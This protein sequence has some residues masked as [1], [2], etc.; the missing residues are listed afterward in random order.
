ML[1]FDDNM[2]TFLPHA[3]GMSRWKWQFQAHW[4]RR[5]L[6]TLHSYNHSPVASHSY[7][8]LI[9]SRHWQIWLA[10]ISLDCCR[11]NIC[12]ENSPTLNDAILDDG[13]IEMKTISAGVGERDAQVGDEVL[14]LRGRI[15]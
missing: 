1:W 12:L 3:S 9:E 8:F 6:R 4:S 5:S 7:N 2:G 13:A 14:S 15:S 11:Y 10:T